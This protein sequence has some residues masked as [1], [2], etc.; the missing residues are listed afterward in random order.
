MEFR[1][2]DTFTDS[3]AR[4][5]GDEQKA[6]KTTAFDLQLN[7]ANPGM[8]LHKLDKAKDPNFWSV[9]ASS[10]IRIIVH[11][12]DSSLLL[13]Y[14]DHHDDAYDWAEKRKLETHPKTGAAQLVEIR[15]T[16]KEITVPKYVDVEK[17]APPKPP[18]FADISEDDLLSYGVPAEWLDDVRKANEDTVLELADHLPSEAAEAL[19]NFATGGMPHIAPSIAYGKRPIRPS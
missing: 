13:C 10:D 16:I 9:R 2:A 6:V 11:K 14:V 12:T 4:L 7:P 17:K 5:T 15:E 19:L 8:Q 3:L 1:I 18:L